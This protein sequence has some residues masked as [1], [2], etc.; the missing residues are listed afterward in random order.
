MR[1]PR[2]K[3]SR[4]RDP[5]LL[6]RSRWRLVQHKKKCTTALVRALERH[7]TCIDRCSG[8]E[9][10][11]VIHR[12]NRLTRASVWVELADRGL[13]YVIQ[14]RLVED[15]RRGDPTTRGV[16]IV[17]LNGRE[18]TFLRRPDPARTRKCFLEPLVMPDAQEPAPVA[19]INLNHK[20]STRPNVIRSG[21]AY[22]PSI[23][24]A[25]DPTVQYLDGDRVRLSGSR[26]NMF[27]RKGIT[28]VACGLAGTSFFKEKDSA[29]ASSWTLN[30]YAVSPSGAET[31]MTQDHIKP[32]S[33][34]GSNSVDN[35][36][37]MCVVCNGK[38][39]NSFGS[40][41]EG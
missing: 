29:S 28:C 8:V 18:Y 16:V 36:Q 38:K 24:L 5:V 15:P 30:L 26:L 7:P 25:L 1:K 27:R 32:V 12:K 11:A 21:S 41:G 20:A 10:D 37:P 40:Q 17:K 31:L 6:E 13:V 19:M 22:P 9:H 34:G 23:I 35:L 3:L 14:Q 2:L 39:G 4:V 33:H